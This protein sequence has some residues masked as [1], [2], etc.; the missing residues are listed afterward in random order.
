MATTPVQKKK[1]WEARS[2]GFSIVQS[3]QRAKISEATAYRMEKAA[4][5]I[6]AAEGLDS[7]ARDYH[8]RKVENKL[9]GPK[10]YEELSPEAKRALNDFGYFR[11]RYFGRVSTPW[12][13]E[14][15]V[16]LVDAL[17]SELKEYIVMN[18]PPG[19]GKTTLL[20]DLTCW[21]ICRN[22]AVRLLTGSATMSLA[23]RNLMR[24]RRS[25][26]RV[27]PETAD[28][29][30]KARGQAFDAEATLSADFGRFRPLDRELWT[31]EAFVV[32][33]PDDAGA[34]SEKEPT[35]SA[36]GMDSGFIGGRFDGCFWD[37][38]VDPR[39]IR[40]AEQR[41]AMEDWYQDVA[42]T[43]LE[44]AGML[45]LIGQRLA[46]DDLYRFALDMSQPLEDESILDDLT[47]EEIAQLRQDKKYRHLVYKAH[48]E[49]RCSPQFHKRGADAYPVGCLLDPRRLPWREISSLMSNRGER[50]QV[51]YQQ[52]D[53]A[54]D[55][56]LV[57][58]EWVYG[59]GES[60]G[61]IDKDRDRWEIP[62][63]MMAQDC[64]VVATAD[65]SPTMFWSIQAWLYHPESKQRVL[66]DLERRKMEANEFLDWDYSRG[67]FIGI[68]EEWQALSEK[69][70]FPISCWVVEQNAAQRFLFQYDHFKRW[71]IARGVE[72]IPHNTTNNKSDPDYGV[73]T[74]G[75]H[76][77]FGRVRL[78]GKGE[79]KVRSMRL[80]D[81]VTRYPHG[82]TD[83]CVMAEW[84]FEWNLDSIYIPPAKHVNVHR[85]SWLG[86][87]KRPS[88]VKPPQRQVTRY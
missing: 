25:L 51:V 28:D 62:R 38:L 32:M 35:L 72:V 7:S 57:Q 20:H 40:S 34:I 73:T 82:R 23:K 6:G 14:A 11:R 70:G 56:V 50:F 48:Y 18:M 64:V 79:G 24:V 76:W 22:R 88:W 36:Y 53:V 58:K 49:D 75:Q 9:S 77:R 45:A 30:L 69:L 17:E 39:K 66:L 21:M 16:A 46:P 27:I 44:P 84:F 13:E 15:G 71:R 1:Y 74:I 5:A 12:Q 85:P 10:S 37:D 83:D 59:H 3:A 41:E 2:A 63:G 52:E 55:E 86:E 31:N 42:E 19:S 87:G 54:L 78:M 47:E 65:P 61:C 67:Q 80:I 68:M 43:R 60:P 29:Q 4:K 33:Q 8:E 81:E 26:E